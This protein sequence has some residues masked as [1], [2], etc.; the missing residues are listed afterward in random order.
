MEVLNLSLSLSFL[1]PQEKG[2]SVSSDLLHHLPDLIQWHSKS[3]TIPPVAHS[4]IGKFLKAA[5]EH[6]ESGVGLIGVAL[7]I[8]EA[9][10]GKL[11]DEV[12]NSLVC[13]LM[14]LTATVH[15]QHFQCC[16]STQPLM[17]ISSIP[18]IPLLLV[19]PP[20][21]VQETITSWTLPPHPPLS[22]LYQW[23]KSSGSCLSLP[24]TSV[25]S[26]AAGASTSSRSAQST[27]SL[28]TLGRR[29]PGV[30]HYVS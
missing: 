19:S 21:P 29:S 23:W 12:S 6:P 20:L 9:S 7:V 22:R 28:C 2:R 17:N 5:Q 15:H 18:P 3:S 14:V 25:C 13:L 26:L 27:M 30:A 8:K 16:Y 11:I 4:I 10:E 24:P 1:P